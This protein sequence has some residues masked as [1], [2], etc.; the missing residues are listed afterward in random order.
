M[1]SFNPTNL[2]DHLKKK[3]PGDY[4]DYKEKKKIR[5]LKEME[6][7]LKEQ[8]AFRQLTMLEAETKV[9]VWD[10]NDPH[11]MRIHKLVGEMIATDN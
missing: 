6:K 9:K 1:K 4:V 3:H 7:K 8:T 11:A 10:I 2:I 5:E